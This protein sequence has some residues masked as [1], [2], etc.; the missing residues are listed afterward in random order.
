PMTRGSAA[1]TAALVAL[2]PGCAGV[3]PPPEPAA[4]AAGGIRDGRFEVIA[5]RAGAVVA[6]PHGTTDTGT[7][8]IGRDLARLTGFSAVLVTG[9]SH[10][11]G[12][13]S[14]YHGNRPT[15]SAAGAPP[16]RAR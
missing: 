13:G 7:D 8:A 1:M 15:E 4:P 16:A 2:L 11:D 9:F 6:A 5:G 12:L 10:V 3:A 14:R